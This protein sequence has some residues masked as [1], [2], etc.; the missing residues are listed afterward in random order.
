[1]IPVKKTPQE[2][3]KTGIWRIPAGIANLGGT[4][5]ILDVRAAA[6]AGKQRKHCCCCHC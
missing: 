3:K 2:W 6:V 1:M 5:T 4:M